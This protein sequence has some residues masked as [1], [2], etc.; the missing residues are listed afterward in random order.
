MSTW[1]RKPADA[2]RNQ[3]STPGD[4]MG[5]RH[6]ARSRGNSSP[7]PPLPRAQHAQGHKGS[8]SCRTLASYSGLRPLPHLLTGQVQV[9]SPLPNRCQW[10]PTWLPSGCH[11]ANVVQEPL[12]LKWT[13]GRGC[14][15]LSSPCH[16]CL[17]FSQHPPS[18]VRW[19]N[20]SSVSTRFQTNLGTTTRPNGLT[21]TLQT[22]LTTTEL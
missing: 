18:T 20:R 7:Q 22:I 8:V 6:Q 17:L 19:G 11:E 16:L 3:T 13:P 2:V 4:G 14:C 12:M 21:L 9:W 10:L 5:R 15:P 1:G